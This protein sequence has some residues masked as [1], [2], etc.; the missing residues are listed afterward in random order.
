M[1]WQ[2]V[3]G[4]YGSYGDYTY[5]SS[6]TYD[7]FFMNEGQNEQYVY[8]VKKYTSGWTA[9]TSGSSSYAKYGGITSYHRFGQLRYKHHRVNSYKMYLLKK[10]SFK[11]YTAS[12]SQ[13]FVQNYK[14][15]NYFGTWSLESMDTQVKI[16]GWN[17]WQFVSI[18]A[19]NS[20][21]GYSYSNEDPS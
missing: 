11:E 6:Y 10:P 1:K 14:V 19:G 8:I 18:N 12:V 20:M 13:S 21:S 15:T 16:N 3:D 9:G 4:T 2:L 7:H 17:G 5:T